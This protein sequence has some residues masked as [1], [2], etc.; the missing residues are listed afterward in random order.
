MVEGVG[1]AGD[2][3]SMSWLYDFYPNVLGWVSF[4]HVDAVGVSVQY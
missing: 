2:E 1:H 4:V 3:S